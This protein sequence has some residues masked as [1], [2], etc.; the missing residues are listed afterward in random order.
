M[1]G[2]GT[3]GD[4]RLGVLTGTALLVRARVLWDPAKHPSFPAFPRRLWSYWAIPVSRVLGIMLARKKG[5]LN[6]VFWHK[7]FS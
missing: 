3:Y 6:T 1:I 4:K 2:I 5:T 7:G